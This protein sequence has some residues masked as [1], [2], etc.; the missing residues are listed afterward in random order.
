MNP[1]PNSIT[2]MT[3]KIVRKTLGLKAGGFSHITIEHGSVL[4]KGETE[5]GILRLP[6]SMMGIFHNELLNN[7]FL[8]LSNNRQRFHNG[9]K[10]EPGPC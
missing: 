6:L 1:D 4:F 7:L 3:P 2:V 8:Y 10:E 5:E 9:A